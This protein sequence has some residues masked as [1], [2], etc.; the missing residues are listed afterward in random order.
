MVNEVIKMN[1]TAMENMFSAFKD[2]EQVLEEIANEVTKLGGQL[3]NGAL[4]GKSG[5]KLSQS[6]KG[7]LVV[8]INKMK[9]ELKRLETDVTKAQ[10]EMQNADE[11]AGG[12]YKGS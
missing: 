6:I 11:I 4:L 1:Y 12:Y 7:D 10:S 5:E 9:D 2:S 3:E 8:A